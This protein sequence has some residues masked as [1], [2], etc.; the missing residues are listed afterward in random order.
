MCDEVVVCAVAGRGI[1]VA[2]DDDEGVGLADTGLEAAAV[3]VF[4]VVFADAAA[5]LAAAGFFVAVEAGLAAVVDFAVAG[6]E[7]AAGFEAGALGVLGV[8]GTATGLGV[9]GVRGTEDE[10]AEGLDV[11]AAAEGFGVTGG[12]LGVVGTAEEEA[13]GA[14][15][16]VVLGAVDALVAAGLEAEGLA[17]LTVVEA[18]FLHKQLAHYC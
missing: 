13:E 9:F 15:V 8:R 17:A 4:V 7:E 14:L 10:E 2:A 6:R 18:F 5:G 16:V 3:V 11:T 1:F 12:A